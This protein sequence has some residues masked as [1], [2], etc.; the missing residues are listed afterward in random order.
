MHYF[1]CFIVF[2]FI[3]LVA[4]SS[5][6]EEEGI[7]TIEQLDEFETKEVMNR[8]G[9]GPVFEFDVTYHQPEQS[10]FELW[11]EVYKDGKLLNSKK[12][13]LMVSGRMLHDSFGWAIIESG[14]GN[15]TIKFYEQRNEEEGGA[16]TTKL[17]NHFEEGYPTASGYL[18]QGTKDLEAGKEYALAFYRQ[19]AQKNQLKTG[20][21]SVE[22]MIDE[23]ALIYLL[24]FQVN[25]IEENE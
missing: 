7:A 12:E 3:V 19:G 15:V 24:K 20:Y 14:Q 18:F 1:K 10:E 9:L 4:C 5:S 17:K 2:S 13:S 21:D 23:S 8:L 22:D 16:Y 11:L 25:K 6:A